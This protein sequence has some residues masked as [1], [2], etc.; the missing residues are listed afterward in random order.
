MMPRVTLTANRSRSITG[1]VPGL[2]NGMGALLFCRSGRPK[3]LET[4]TFG[5][6]HWDGTFVGFS[7]VA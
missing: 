2:V 1:S 5:G 3:C 6:E 7:I 4:Y